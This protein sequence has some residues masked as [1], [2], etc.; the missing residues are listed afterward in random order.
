MTTKKPKRKLQVAVVDDNRPKRL[1]ERFGNDEHKVAKEGIPRSKSLDDI[2]IDGAQ[3]PRDD[4]INPESPWFFPADLLEAATEANKRE[5]VSFNQRYAMKF[6]VTDDPVLSYMHRQAEL[7]GLGYIPDNDTPKTDSEAEEFQA[8]RERHQPLR[9]LEL[10]RARFVHLLELLF[11][12]HQGKARRQLG[13]SKKFRDFL[14]CKEDKRIDSERVK[15]LLFGYAMLLAHI[16]SIRDELHDHEREIWVAMQYLHDPRL[17]LDGKPLKYD[18]LGTEKR[19]IRRKIQ[20]IAGDNALV[21]SEPYFM[22]MRALAMLKHPKRRPQAATEIM[23]AERLNSL[24]I[25]REWRTLKTGARGGDQ[26]PIEGFLA[27]DPD[28]ME[29]A[30]NVFYP[31]LTWEE[32]VAEDT[33]Y[34]IRPSTKAVRRYI[35]FAK[36][37]SELQA[38]L[39]F[40]ARQ[41]RMRGLRHNES[42]LAELPEREKDARTVALD[43]LEAENVA[44]GGRPGHISLAGRNKLKAYSMAER[45]ARGTAGGKAQYNKKALPATLEDNLKSRGKEANTLGKLNHRKDKALLAEQYQRN[46]AERERRAQVIPKYKSVRG[47]TMFTSGK[48]IRMRNEKKVQYY[49]EAAFANYKLKRWGKVF[50]RKNRTPKNKG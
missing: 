4:E 38:H 32:F 42:L 10:Q 19:A 27:A 18:D 5:F 29:R 35:A 23:R 1:A 40:V 45:N 3:I 34:S 50:T 16:N 30:W 25:P 37:H 6:A 47:K 26:I 43:R 12:P 21:V 20:R 8:Y 15:E 2:Y 48:A 9:I 11:G 7:C 44:N 46:R 36:G 49:R 33:K 41:L 28:I 13:F 14:D 17:H 39:E 24:E 22:P 31:D